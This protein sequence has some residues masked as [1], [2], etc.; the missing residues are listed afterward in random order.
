LA[1]SE[2]FALC[3]RA[4][5]RAVWQFLGNLRSET[6]SEWRDALDATPALT[7]YN[8]TR[9]YPTDTPGSPT[10]QKVGGSNP[11]ERARERP[12]RS[13]VQTYLATS[14]GEDSSRTTRV[15]NYATRQRDTVRERS[16]V[17]SIRH[18][19]SKLRVREAS[20]RSR[21]VSRTR[22]SGAPCGRWTPREPMAPSS[23]SGRVSATCCASLGCGQDRNSKRRLDLGQVSSVRALVTLPSARA[24]ARGS[25]GAA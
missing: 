21:R 22:R 6:A 17:R 8:V 25:G 9:H 5:P 11:S 12:G 15:R 7:W 18:N 4:E 3:K 10:D 19:V 2:R 13:V 16:D 14:A 24:L 20:R 23:R 1:I